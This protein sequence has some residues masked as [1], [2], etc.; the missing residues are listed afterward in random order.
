MRSRTIQ[1]VLDETLLRAADRV[2][3]SAKISRSE[4]IRDA[5]REHLKRRRIAAMQERERRGY[6][7]FPPVEFDVWDRVLAWP[8][9]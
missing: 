4:L 9:D 5:L 1:V 3:K 2:V 6:E 7:R 8:T